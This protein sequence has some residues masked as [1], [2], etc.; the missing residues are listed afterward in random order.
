MRTVLIL[1]I[2][3]QFLELVYTQRG[4]QVN[5]PS[6]CDNAV[7]R[8]GFGYNPHPFDCTQFVQCF[9]LPGR[10]V[11]PV[12]RNC[13]FGQFWDQSKIGCFPA[14][15]VSCPFDK[16]QI[17]GSKFYKHTDT[18]K[19]N[20]YWKCVNGKAFGQ[21]C[22]QGERFVQEL[23][24][25]PDPSCT[26]MCPLKDRVPGCPRRPISG[27]PTKYEQYTDN[28]IWQREECP[29]GAAYDPADCRCSLE[30]L[31]VPGRRCKPDVVINFD[32]GVPEDVSG[33]N[34]K[35]HAEGVS[36]YRGAAYFRGHS[37][38]VIDRLRPS[39]YDEGVLIIKLKF[40]EDNRRRRSRGLQ[41]LVTNGHCGKQPSVVIAK[42]PNSIL[43]GAEANI[44]RSFPL[45]IVNK[46]WKEVV[47][48]KDDFKLHGRV[49]GAG[50]NDWCTGKLKETNCGFQIGAA[51]GLAGF[52]GLID[53]I[54]IYRCKPLD[55][56]LNIN[57]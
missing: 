16:C 25:V 57:Y 28:G 44:S 29:P 56:V 52:V 33:N 31:I 35:I 13:E 21:C 2:S 24:C 19:C 38:L 41:G 5:E 34:N 39:K 55:T 50:F 43:L 15:Y 40:S 3:V 9:Y 17:P 10:R 1:V 53:D 11:E 51:P 47:Y 37:R 42:L 22:P 49:C 48:I 54:S 6:V 26:D 45:P 27:A 46:P 20:A 23:G 4:R 32:K 30:G 14:K 36:M 12:Y 8:H 7:K 18:N